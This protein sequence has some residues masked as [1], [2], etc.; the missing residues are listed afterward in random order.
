MALLEQ[1]LDAI[2]HDDHFSQQTCDK[3]F[4]ISLPA[5]ANHAIFL[6]LVQAIH[7]EAPAVQ[8]SEHSAMISPS[9]ALESGL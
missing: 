1:Q 8:L 4:S 2:L 6:P 9:R 5:L 3:H 7:L